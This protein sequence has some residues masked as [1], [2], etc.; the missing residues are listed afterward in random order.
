MKMA[1]REILQK[2]KKYDGRNMC[3]VPKSCFPRLLKMLFDQLQHNLEKN[4][5]SGFRKTGIAPLNSQ[6]VLSR[7]P[8][9]GDGV[10]L[11][12]VDESFVTFLKEMRYGSLNMSETKTKKKIEVIASKS[13]DPNELQAANTEKKTVKS[14]NKVES[15]KSASIKNKTKRTPNSCLDLTSSRKSP[16]PST[17]YDQQLDL[18]AISDHLIFPKEDICTSPEKKL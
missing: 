2:W 9:E 18:E 3:S 7:L 12:A 15:T 8:N 17:S 10:N 1:W 6:E 4:S 5:L 13:V 16:I 14:N 11:N